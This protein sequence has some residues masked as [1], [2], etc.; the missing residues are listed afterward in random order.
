MDEKK[1]ARRA[2][3]AR[4]LR[5][6]RHIHNPCIII[7]TKQRNL[8]QIPWKSFDSQHLTVR[9]AMQTDA[10]NTRHRV[11]LA[12]QPYREVHHFTSVTSIQ[13]RSFLCLFETT[14]H[15]G[16]FFRSRFC[17]SLLDQPPVPDKGCLALAPAWG[18]VQVVTT[19]ST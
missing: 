5:L 13:Q 3:A 16:H 18:H 1:Q 7:H 9:S 17:V 2:Y 14:V 6:F 11:F 12:G 4:L 10:K 15:D 8:G 19:S